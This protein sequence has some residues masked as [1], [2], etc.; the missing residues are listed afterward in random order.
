MYF[1]IPET[2]ECTDNKPAQGSSYTVKILLTKKFN[3]KNFKKKFFS[4]KVV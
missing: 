1:S 2:Q 3:S 4:N